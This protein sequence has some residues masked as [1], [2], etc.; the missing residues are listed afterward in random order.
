MNRDVS[1][2]KCPSCDTGKKTYLL[3]PREP[4]CPHLHH[5]K[6]GTCMMYVPLMQKEQVNFKNS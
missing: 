6:E 2:Q 3:D 4:F 5:N 1:G